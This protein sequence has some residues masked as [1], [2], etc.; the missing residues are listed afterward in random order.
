M[1]FGQVQHSNIL[2]YH[3]LRGILFCKRLWIALR[4]TAASYMMLNFTVANGGSLHSYDTYYT[5]QP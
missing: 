2:T 1:F 5:L 4:Q 3:K